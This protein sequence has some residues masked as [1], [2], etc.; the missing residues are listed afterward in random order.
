MMSSRV[1]DK[2]PGSAQKKAGAQYEN[3]RREVKKLNLKDQQLQTASYSVN[4]EWD[5]SNNKRTLRGYTALIGLRIETSETA[6]ASEILA[7]AEK[8]GLQD[9]ENPSTF[10]SPDLAQKEYEAC[11]KVAVE[12]ARS[13]A[14]K[15]A[16]AA[17]KKVG[18]LASLDET[19]ETVQQPIP[20]AKMSMAEDS[21]GGAGNRIGYEIKSELMEVTVY[22]KYILR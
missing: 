6:R 18:E 7:L 5:Y 17:G 11:L 4:P 8:L 14:D 3:L 9:V 1:T 13:K 10:L 12:S 16:S 20:M 19:P 2:D 22:A 21:S 15:M